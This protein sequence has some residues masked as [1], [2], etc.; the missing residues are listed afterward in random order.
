MTASPIIHYT[1]DVK[2][3][4]KI[5]LILFEIL[6]LKIKNPGSAIRGILFLQRPASIVLSI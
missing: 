4:P 5:T 6:W 1:T 2:N 3:D